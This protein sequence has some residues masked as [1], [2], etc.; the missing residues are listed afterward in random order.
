M[1]EE[2]SNDFPA[3]CSVVPIYVDVLLEVLQIGNIE[4]AVCPRVPYMGMEWDVASAQLIGMVVKPNFD[5]LTKGGLG[6]N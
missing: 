6:G 4:V 5:L 2:A 1:H 3:L